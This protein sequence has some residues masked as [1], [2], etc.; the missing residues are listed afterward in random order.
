M[1]LSNFQNPKSMETSIFNIFFT[2]CCNLPLNGVAQHFQFR[3]IA[4][5]IGIRRYVRN[6]NLVYIDTWARKTFSLYPLCWNLLL[7]GA[8]AHHLLYRSTLKL[9]IHRYMSTEN[10]FL[11]STLL[12]RT[13]D[14]AA[15]HQ[16]LC[17]STDRKIH[18][19]TKQINLWLLVH[20]LLNRYYRMVNMFALSILLKLTTRW[21]CSSTLTSMPFNRLHEN[22]YAW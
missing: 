18:T 19:T 5:K 2:F 14:A 9:G 4:M 20:W 10:I 1:H 21:R 11:L 3:S 15:A 7:D 6:V 17:R 12:K 8:A 16:R 22:W 13:T